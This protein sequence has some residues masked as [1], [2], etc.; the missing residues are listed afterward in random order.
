MRH[1]SSTARRLFCAKRTIT[2][3]TANTPVKRL[4]LCVQMMYL[5][6]DIPR[7]RTAYM[8]FLKELRVSLPA[9]AAAID[10]V[11]SHV[12]AGTLYQALKEM[13]QLM[14]VEETLSMSD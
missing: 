11:D 1:S 2:A 3:E 12:S 8:G 7:Y 13:R 6:N 9:S 5:K 14:K 10:A 4:Y